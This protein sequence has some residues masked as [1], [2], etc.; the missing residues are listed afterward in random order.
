[1]KP[2][3]VSAVTVT[4]IAEDASTSGTIS[5]VVFSYGDALFEEEEALKVSPPTDGDGTVRLDR[6]D[7]DAGGFYEGQWLI[8]TGSPSVRKNS[9]VTRV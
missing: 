9:N 6:L 1:M 2:K 7:T 8:I 3:F 4:L 5:G